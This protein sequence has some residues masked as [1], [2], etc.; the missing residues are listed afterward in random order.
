A[1]LTGQ[2]SIDVVREAEKKMPE[3]I[4]TQHL[5]YDLARIGRTD[6]LVGIPCFNSARTVGLVVTAVDVGLRK[7]FPDLRATVLISDGG[8]GDGTIST[9]LEAGVGEHAA[10]YLV[11]PS[12]RPPT[13]LAC[14]YRGI[15]GKGS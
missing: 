7:F 11:D 15:L 2:S 5:R 8:S 3:E 9:A 12:T 14:T 10:A 4:R 1:T 6:V 13:K